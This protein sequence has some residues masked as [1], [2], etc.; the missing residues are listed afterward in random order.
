M[1]S[2]SRF[3]VEKMLTATALSQQSPFPLMRTEHGQLQRDSRIL[4]T[5][6]R[7]AVKPANEYAEIITVKD[8]GQ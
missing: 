4:E 7:K 2:L 6:Q 5:A 3:N 8:L 1:F